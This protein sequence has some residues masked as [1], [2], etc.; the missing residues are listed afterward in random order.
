MRELPGEEV[1][2]QGP[3]LC[4]RLGLDVG[5]VDGE[6]VEHDVRGRCL[7]GQL[8]PLAELSTHGPASEERRSFA[9]QWESTRLPR[10]FCRLRSMH[11]CIVQV[12][13]VAVSRFPP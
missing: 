6:R 12:C 13:H 2:E 3:A 5:A 4:V 10:Q 8:T 11:T 7:D 1:S 9:I